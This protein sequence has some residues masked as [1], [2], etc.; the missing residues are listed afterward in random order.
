VEEAQQLIA[1]ALRF[2]T[3]L[4]LVTICFSAGLA[5]IFP[6][7]FHLPPDQHATAS[8]AVFLLGLS[9][10]ISFPCAA[11]PAVLQGLQRYDVNNLIGMFGILVI[12]ITTVV[13]LQM[14]GGLISM[15]AIPIP[16][17]LVMQIPAI[18]AIRRVAPELRFGWKGA[19]TRPA[20]TILSYSSALFVWNVAD[21]LQMKTDEIVIGATLPIASITPYAIAHRL[22]EGAQILTD[23]L[24][25]VILPLASRLQAEDDRA[26]LQ[27]LYLTGTRLTLAFA[28][29][30]GACTALLARPLAGRINPGRDGQ[31]PLARPDLYLRWPGESGPVAGPGAPPGA[32]RD[33]PGHPDPDRD[34]VPV[35][36]I[37]LYDSRGR[38]QFSGG[39]ERGPSAGRHPCCAG[40]PGPGFVTA[41]P[42]THLVD[43]DPLC[44]L[45]W[46]CDL[47][48]RLPVYE[49]QRFRTANLQ[50]T[51]AASPSICQSS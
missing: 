1:T 46:S 12:S 28:L 48:V 50:R 23:Q 41:D 47:W 34:R 16:I 10:G 21:R 9:L 13:A 40:D 6:K 43:N 24:V 7:L 30:V 51:G 31:A 32:G 37:P 33:R 44:R 15:A 17:T 5:P 45:R 35:H 49:R 27:R 38:G 26:S 20:R 2:Y 11:A 19:H 22:S 14:G 3:A 8:W 36:H 25:K 39:M 4:G 42:G 29:P 18:W